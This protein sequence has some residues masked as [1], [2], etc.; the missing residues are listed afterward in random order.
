MEETKGM[1]RSELIKHVKETTNIKT[2]KPKTVKI[3]FQN[4]ENPG[5]DVPFTYDGESFHLY[6]GMTYDLSVGVVNHLN[7]LTYPIKKWV[8]K[9]PEDEHAILKEV[10]KTHRFNCIVIE[11]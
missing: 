1:K 7:N 2:E 4:S 11:I 8:R 6:D 10:G 3:R 5:G 9:N